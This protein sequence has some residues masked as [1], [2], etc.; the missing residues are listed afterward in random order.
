[1]AD[2]RQ[3]L[4]DQEVH[5]LLEEFRPSW[6]LVLFPEVEREWSKCPLRWGWVSLV[7]LQVTTAEQRTDPMYS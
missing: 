6:D 1:M 2:V 5:M 3:H 4:P 7:L